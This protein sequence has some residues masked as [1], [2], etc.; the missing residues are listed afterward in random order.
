MGQI[1]V[2]HLYSS[3]CFQLDPEEF[4]CKVIDRI[5]SLI[6]GWLLSEENVIQISCHYNIFLKY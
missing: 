1:T 6:C 4:F 5:I 2:V 3:F